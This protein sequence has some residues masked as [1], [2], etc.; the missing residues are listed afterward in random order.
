MSKILELF[1]RSTSIDEGIDWHNIEEIQECPF[2]HRK[3]IKVRKSQPHVSIGTCTVQHGKENAKPVVICPHR[4]IAKHQIFLDCL[5]LLTRHEPGN[6]LHVVSEITIP[7]GSV[8]YFFV[9]AHSEKVIDFVGIEIQ[10]LDTTGTAWP[11][12]QRFLSEQGISTRTEDVDSARSFGMNWKMSAKTILVQILH[13][14]QTFENLNKH[15]VLVVQDH[16]VEYMRSN[17]RLEH[18]NNGLLGD[19]MHVHE[20]TLKKAQNLSYQLEL[21]SRISTDAA[22]IAIS[23]GLQ[24]DAN[25]ELEQIVSKLESKI[26]DETRISL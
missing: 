12:R 21:A 18:L 25:V 9:S 24:A 16:F 10:T 22:G 6:Q 11:E 20:Y 8:D 26:S 3:C 17:F 2:L 4:M 7:G 14:I 15:L 1:G 19:S 23:L 5:H 13:K